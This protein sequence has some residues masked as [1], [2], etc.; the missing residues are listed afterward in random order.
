MS[1]YKIIKSKEI[2]VTY[3]ILEYYARG[4]PEAQRPKL[5]YYLQIKWVKLYN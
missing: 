1:T 3:D 2:R 4:A 5:Q